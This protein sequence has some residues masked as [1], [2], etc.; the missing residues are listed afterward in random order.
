MSDSPG[1]SIGK[2]GWIDMTVQ[3]AKDISSFYATVVGLDPEP[4]DMGGYSDFTMTMPATGEAVAGVCHARGTNSDMPGGWLVYFIVADVD[5]SASAC[6]E[7]GGRVRIAPRG[8]AGGRFCVIEDPN[9][10]TTA[11]Y[12]P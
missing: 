11:L 6:E 8:L 5:A 4:V 12:Q 10:A 1:N 9:G 7:L 3:N 2:A